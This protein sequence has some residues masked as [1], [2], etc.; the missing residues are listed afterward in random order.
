[1]GTEKSELFYRKWLS[2]ELQRRRAINPRYS[3]R[4]FANFL[5]IDIASLSRIL[6]GRQPIGVRAAKHVLER[7]KIPP[8]DLKLFVESIA[9]ERRRMAI[10]VLDDPDKDAEIHATISV[11]S[12]DR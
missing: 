12:R 3:M 7:L 5:K 10:E 11:E 2:E 8:D 9:E 4:A 6:S 1:M